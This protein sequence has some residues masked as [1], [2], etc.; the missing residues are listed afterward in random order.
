LDG[1][2]PTV[3]C[4]AVV[5]KRCEELGRIAKIIASLEELAGDS[6]R[7]GLTLKEYRGIRGE[8]RGKV[9]FFKENGV[10]RWTLCSSRWKWLVSFW[11]SKNTKRRMRVIKRSSQV[12]LAPFLFK[13]KIVCQ[14]KRFSFSLSLL[15]LKRIYN[16]ARRPPVLT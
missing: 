16:G 13:V 14:S 11:R 5:L 2:A 12:I 1:E 6:S 10:W 7:N 3:F 15:K 4:R 9:R 8:A